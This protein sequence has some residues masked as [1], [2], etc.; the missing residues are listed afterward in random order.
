MGGYFMILTAI[1][2]F[3]L[4]AWFVMLLTRALAAPLGINALGYVD[5]MLLTITLWI[6][7][8]PL[9]AG[10]RRRRR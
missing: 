9:V 3:F 2:G 8:A 10:A 4:S 6:A 1:P 7:V 5:S